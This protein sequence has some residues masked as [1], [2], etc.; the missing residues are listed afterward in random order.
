VTIVT[1]VL[2]DVL[3]ERVGEP[4][5]R[6]DALTELRERV[7]DVT[8]LRDEY[9]LEVFVRPI[10]FRGGDAIGH[11]RRAAA[12][13]RGSRGADGPRAARRARTRRPLWEFWETDQDT[14]AMFPAES[15]PGRRVCSTMPVVRGRAAELRV[16]DAGLS[17]EDDGRIVRERASTAA[18][19]CIYEANE[20]EPRRSR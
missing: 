10:P 5:L 17:L 7:G 11:D 19:R 4:R 14:F 12:A 3:A 15:W 6:E 2:Y 13:R 20:N 9:S 1:P 16:L 18:E 8:W